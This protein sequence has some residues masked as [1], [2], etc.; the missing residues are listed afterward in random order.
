MKEIQQKQF[1]RVNGLGFGE[2]TKG[3]TVQWLVREFKAHTVWRSGGWQGG[4]H[5]THDDGREMAFSFFGAG[6]FEGA[7]TYLKH[8]VISPVELFNEAVELEQKG[9]PQALDLITIDKDCLATTP[10]HSAIS[11]FREI[12]RGKDRKG[13]IG[14]GV[15]EAIKDAQ[16]PELAIRTGEFHDFETLLRKIENIRRQKLS[17][18]Q[19]MLTSYRVTVPPDA[20]F[21]LSILQDKSLVALTAEA[22]LY[23]ANLVAIV[24]EV[25][26]ENLLSQKGTIVNE[27]SHG[28]L[29]HPRYGFLPHVTQIDPTS[30]DVANTLD[31]HHYTG[32]KLRFGIVRSY[33]TRHGAG[34][35]VSFNQELTDSLVETHNN[36]AND[37]LGE[38]RTGYFDVVALRYAL[39]FSGGATSYDG[40]VLSYLDV[41]AKRKEWQVCEAY[42]Y[43]GRDKDLER[44]FELKGKR[45]MG[46][47]VYPDTLDETHIQ[48]QLELTRLLK[49]CFPVL[50][51]LTPTRS[52][53]LVQIFIEYVEGELGVPVA[54]TAYGP[55][56]N[57][58]H[59]LRSFS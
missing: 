1:I 22:C 15:G 54:G 13:T 33:L 7:R 28:T 4:H 35:L 20:L 46:I 23:L 12:L 56:V 59:F 14:K 9:I 5:I 44:F 27:V 45:I 17:Q 3:N 31:K 57:D 21:E 26:L 49:D 48:H 38:F 39:A 36:A 41:L 18:A 24:D 30:Q 47:K 16:N 37:W 52:K 8:M 51:T 58:R 42:E 50:K 19:D 11:R 55:K 43:R 53:D 10:Y 6:T 29:H 32:R 34:P 40:L 2:E 25:Y